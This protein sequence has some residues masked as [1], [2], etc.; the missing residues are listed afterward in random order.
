V[1]IGLDDV[2]DDDDALPPSPP[3]SMDDVAMAPVVCVASLVLLLLLLLDVASD[4]YNLVDNRPNLE[5][6]MDDNDDA[7]NDRTQVASLYFFI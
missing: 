5:V 4:W 3:S 6:R 1:F 7:I 2:D